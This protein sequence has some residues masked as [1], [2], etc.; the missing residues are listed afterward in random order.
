M[1]AHLRAI[2]SAQAT[3]RLVAVMHG[4]EPRATLLQTTPA[5][6]HRRPELATA[7]TRELIAALCTH[8]VVSAA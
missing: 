7:L 2:F 6:F 1:A 4:G 8:P 3:P 5:A